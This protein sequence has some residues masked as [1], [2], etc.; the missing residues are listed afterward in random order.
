MEAGQ[1]PL[2]PA[3]SINTQNSWGL[4]NETIIHFRSQEAKL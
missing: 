2:F 1:R 4:Y 3:Y